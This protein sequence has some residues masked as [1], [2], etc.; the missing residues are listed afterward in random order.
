M[1]KQIS[2]AQILKELLDEKHIQHVDKF[3]LKKKK[4]YAA[5]RKFVAS[6]QSAY[7]LSWMKLQWISLYDLCSILYNPS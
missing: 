2:E 3:I 7:A 4:Y 6:P 1:K 5:Q